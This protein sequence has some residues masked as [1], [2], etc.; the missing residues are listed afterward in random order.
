MHCIILRERGKPRLSREGKFSQVLNNL[1][2]SDRNSATLIGTAGAACREN[3]GQLRREERIKGE[4]HAELYC[5]RELGYWKT[6]GC[7]QN[8]TEFF[9]ASIIYR[10]RSFLPGKFLARLRH[11]SIPI[12]T[13]K[14]AVREWDREVFFFYKDHNKSEKLIHNEITAIW[15]G[16]VFFFNMHFLS[17]QKPCV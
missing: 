4:K 8:I 3:Q 2:S 12:Y 5:E 14:S 15:C 6:A 1:C 13:G 7:F 11:L 9:I 17:E 10:E 16:S